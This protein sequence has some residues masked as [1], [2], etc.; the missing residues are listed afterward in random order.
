MA[1][2]SAVIFSSASSKVAPMFFSEMTL[3]AH[4][5]VKNDY[6]IVYGGGMTGLMGRL[7]DAAL[8][9]GGEVIGVIPSY[10]AKD[11]IVHPNLTELIVVDNLLD[12]KR[13]MIEL[14]SAAIAFP[15]GIG[16]LDEVTEALA[17]KQLGENSKP[18]I[19]HNFLD[20]WSP[21]LNFFE[22]LHS[23]H[24]IPQPLGELFAVKDSTLEVVKYLEHTLA[25]V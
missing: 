21:L 15:G 25:E 10:L 17:L 19:F 12:R 16:T 7:A 24:M 2:K 11:G 4:E 13:R 18:V 5:L 20:F 23:R 8:E 1:V 14:A 9:V 22:E 3:L 6:R